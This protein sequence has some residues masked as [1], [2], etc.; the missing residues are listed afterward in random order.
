[1]TQGSVRGGA[2]GGEGKGV[3]QSMVRPWNRLARAVME[4]KEYLDNVLR[5]R[6]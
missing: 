3:H 2:D 5:H 6:V 1:L 4:F